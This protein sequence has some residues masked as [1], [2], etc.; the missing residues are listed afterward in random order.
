M[1]QESKL[2]KGKESPLIPGFAPIRVDRKNKQGRGLISYVK[3][4]RFEK[5]SEESKD[6]TEVSTFSVKMSK[7]KFIKLSTVPQNHLRQIKYSD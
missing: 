5:N 4:L 6:A 3:N 1:I 7:K 2:S